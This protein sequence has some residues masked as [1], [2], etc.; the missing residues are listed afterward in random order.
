MTPG[1][2]QQE[3]VQEFEPAVHDARM[4]VVSRPGH[5]NAT[6]VRGMEAE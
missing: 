5:F 4:V 2:V 1:G 3:V 6:A